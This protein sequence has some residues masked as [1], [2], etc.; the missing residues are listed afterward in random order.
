M[1]KETHIRTLKLVETYL[2]SH[3]EI[4]EKIR[5]LIW[6]LYQINSLDNLEKI[7]WD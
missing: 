6:K 1:L 5:N 4:P 3:I 7:I 2:S